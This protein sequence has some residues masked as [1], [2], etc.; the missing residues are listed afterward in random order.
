VIA[1]A[2]FSTA[3]HAVLIANGTSVSGTFGGAVGF[4]GSANAGTATII[5][6]GAAGGDS[7]VDVA[8]VD[9][10]AGSVSFTGTS[11]GGTAR[12]ELLGN[13]FLDISGHTRL[14]MQIG[15]IEGQGSVLLNKNNMAVGTNNLSTTFSGRILQTGHPTIGGSIN[16]VGSGTWA[17][18]GANT[19]TAGTIVNEGFLK[20]SNTTGSATGSGA[21]QV[22]GG[23]LGGVGILAGAVTVGSGN[24]SGAF[25]APGTGSATLTLQS[26]LSL[27]GDS[28]YTWRFTTPSAKADKVVANGVTIKSGAQFQ[29]VAKGNAQLTMGTSL[30]AISNTA[31]TPISGTFNN[32]P[33]GSTVTVGNNK[34]QADYE[35]GDGNDLTL[36]VVP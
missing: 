12:L 3:G 7:E 17:L 14:G 30:T 21:V 16:K 28:T 5:A 19:Y 2:D 10:R 23:T 35:G 15:S 22:N 25:L 20:V 8:G 31:A 26:S 34:F 13:A 24:G 27:K 4:N 18:G 33:D 36:T 29:A 9:A 32:L 11:S 1:F 6:N